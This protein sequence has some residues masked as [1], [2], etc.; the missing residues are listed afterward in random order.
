MKSSVRGLNYN[1]GG[2]G[3]ESFG[4][5]F[6]YPRLIRCLIIPLWLTLVSG[7]VSLDMD[8][9]SAQLINT[10]TRYEEFLKKYPDKDTPEIQKARKWIGDTDYAFLAT[11]RLSAD[12]WNADAHRQRIFSGF[13]QSYPDSTY[14]PLVKDYIQFLNETGGR[15]MQ[16]YKN[17]IANHPNNPFV[18]EA[19]VIVPILWLKETGTHNVG[20]SINIGKLV[21]GGILLGTSDKAKI[22]EKAWQEIRGELEREGLKTVLLEDL[23][24]QRTNE[25]VEALITVNYSEEK[26]QRASL[27]SGTGY[28]PT[29]TERINE[30]TASLIVDTL[31]G[32]PSASVRSLTVRKDGVI[33]Y[34]SYPDLSSVRGDINSDVFATVG[35]TGKVLIFFLLRQR[36]LAPTKAEELL[37]HLKSKL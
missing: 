24:T 17:F 29:P 27:Y 9:S 31:F 10:R 19:R 37:K 20:V 7:C 25:K 8:W 1:G 33:Y 34:S 11:C 18:A 6:M 26:Q 12:S 23:N 35:D 4:V 36:D 5:M 13:L 14:A 32:S 30:A 16:L 3:T 21:S 15:K 28:Q 22:R 2:I